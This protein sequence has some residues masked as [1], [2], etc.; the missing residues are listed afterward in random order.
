MISW[1]EVGI[2]TA[3][4]STISATLIKIFGNGRKCYAKHE[5]IYDDIE[6]RVRERQAECVRHEIDR[7]EIEK[8][9]SLHARE[10][11]IHETQI[12]TILET[13]H[14]IRRSQDDII[15]ILTKDRGNA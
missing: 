3:I 5:A 8:I 7:K 4:T 15:K 10:V 6:Q 1:P 12:K 11:A 13:L 9:V 2:A 14:E